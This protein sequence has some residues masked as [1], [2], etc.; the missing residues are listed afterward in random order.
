LQAAFQDFDKAVE[1][2]PRNAHVY[3]NRGNLFYILK[4]YQDAEKDFN[5]GMRFQTRA[6]F[7][8]GPLNRVGTA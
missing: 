2:D 3:Y 8:D 7:P 6:V 5:T 4:Q 1:L